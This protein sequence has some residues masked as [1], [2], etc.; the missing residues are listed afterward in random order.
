[1][2]NDRMLKRREGRERLKQTKANMLQY[3]KHL[4]LSIISVNS[5]MTLSTNI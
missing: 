5:L 1:M 3:S 4:F 2:N